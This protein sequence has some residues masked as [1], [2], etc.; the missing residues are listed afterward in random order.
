MLV[1]SD[2][3]PI[4]GSAGVRSI[5]IAPFSLSVAG[6]STL[7]R[8]SSVCS[9]SWMYSRGGINVEQVGTGQYRR[10]EVHHSSY[11]ALYNSIYIICQYNRYHDEEISPNGE[12]LPQ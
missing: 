3:I 5:E 12:N 1:N 4:I 2:S 6:R 7:D 11:L 8:G 9:S 10:S